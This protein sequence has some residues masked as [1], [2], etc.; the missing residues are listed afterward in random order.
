MAGIYSATAMYLH[1]LV[2]SLYSSLYGSWQ[3]LRLL[4]HDQTEQ[5]FK[6]S[7]FSPASDISNFHWE[8]W[9]TCMI[10]MSC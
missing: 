2:N 10:K 7:F 1:W 3:S 6:G 4:G 5:L 9:Y 8:Q